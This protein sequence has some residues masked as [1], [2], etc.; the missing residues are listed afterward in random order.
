[1]PRRD[2]LPPVERAVSDALDD[3]LHRHH[4]I[5]TAWS[6]PEDFLAALRNEGYDIVPISEPDTVPVDG[7]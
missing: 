4:G 7:R 2:E 1:M 6:N 5:M 3:V